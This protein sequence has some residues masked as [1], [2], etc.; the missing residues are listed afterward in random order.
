MKNG[1]TTSS[2][3]LFLAVPYSK[4]FSKRFNKTFRSPGIQVQFTGNMTISNLFVALRDKDSTAQKSVVIYRYKCTQVD[5]EEE[6]IRELGR[7][8]VEK[9]QRTPKSPLSHLP[10]QP[11]HGTLYQYELLHHY[12]KGGTWHH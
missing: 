7:S 8:F 4:S 2:G 5:W 9:A 3:N 1:T 10:T 12:R 6:C 11:G